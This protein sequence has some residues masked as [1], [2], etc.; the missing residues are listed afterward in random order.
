M[1]RRTTSY[2]LLTKRETSKASS[3]L[4]VRSI[5]L[6]RCVYRCLLYSVFF[7]SFSPFLVQRHIKKLRI[8]EILIPKSK[9]NVPRTRQGPAAKASKTSSL[10]PAVKKILSAHKKTP[11]PAPE[12]A[13]STTTTPTATLEL[14]QSTATASAQRSR[15]KTPPSL[16]H[17]ASKLKALDPAHSGSSYNPSF[18]EHQV[19]ILSCLQSLVFSRLSL[20]SF[21]LIFCMTRL[22]WQ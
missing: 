8:E 14:W 12:T 7:P 1:E 21:D 6:D 22:H 11:S 2:S 17:P 20:V 15:K 10:D 5:V 9:I 18:E 16:L 19:I 4:P 13:V 3:S